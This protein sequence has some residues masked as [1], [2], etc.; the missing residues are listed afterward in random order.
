MP[1]L[2]PKLL[3][4]PLLAQ[5]GEQAPAPVTPPPAAVTAAPAAPSS[6]GDREDLYEENG[7][8]YAKGLYLEN[9]GTPEDETRSRKG[10]AL[11]QSIRQR[12]IDKLEAHLLKNKD[13]RVR[14]EILHRLSQMYEQQAEVISRRTDIKDKNV[15]MFTALRSSN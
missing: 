9:N 7:M 10:E 4:F 2:L 3:L 13:K 1:M 6:K 12:G 15:P 11:N 5:A 14:R 8:Q